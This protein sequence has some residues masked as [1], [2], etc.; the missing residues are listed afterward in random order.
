MTPELIKAL[1]RRIASTSIGAPTARGMG[2]AGTVAAA[3]RFL[4]DLSLARL[5]CRSAASFQSTLD[6]VTREYMRHLPPDARHWGSARKFL[7]IFL[8]HVVYSSYL[9]EE[10]RLARIVPW[11]EVPLDSHVARGL[12][13]EPGGSSLPRWRT[14]IGL[15]SA[16]S[17][18]YQDFAAQVAARKRCER[19]H[20][21]LLYWRR[22][23]NGEQFGS[24]NAG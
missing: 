2:P 3:R 11:L 8:R 10:Y 20:L 13:G 7:N 12:R 16:T 19:V 14:V 23:Q 4:A 17:K 6:R 5:R 1:H 21:D 15:D 24:A 22:E 9:C 18:C